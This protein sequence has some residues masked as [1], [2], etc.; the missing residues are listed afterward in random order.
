MYSHA[1]VCSEITRPAPP[2][3]ERLFATHYIH[4]DIN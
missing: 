2:R 3:R 4:F 1:L